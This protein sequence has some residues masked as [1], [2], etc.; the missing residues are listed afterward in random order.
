MS[1]S[2]MPTMSLIASIA[3]ITPMM[4]GQHAQNPALGAAWHHAGRRRFGIEAAVARPAQIRRKNR[5]LSVKPEDR[6]VDV[7][8]FLKDTDVVGEIAGRKIVRA[9]DDDVVGS[10]NF[11]R[12]FRGEEAVVEIDLH[13]R[14]DLLDCV[15]WHC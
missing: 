8:L 5:A 7:R 9:V 4:P 12:V 6:A 10:H 15:P 3:C 1:E 2:P 11:Y 14:I 13:I